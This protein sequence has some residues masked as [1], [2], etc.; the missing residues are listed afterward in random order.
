MHGT[1]T[2][3]TT[4]EKRLVLGSLCIALFMVMLDG[5]VVNVALPHIQSDLSSGVSGL[6]WIVDGYVLALASLM[7]TGGTLGDLF[8]RKRMLM[9]G[10]AIFTVGSAVCGIAPGV[11][12]LIAG[13]IL[14]GVGA[15][16]L[17]PGTLSIL[18][19]VYTDPKERA[20]AI[21]IWAGVS[22][23]ALASGPVLGGF[24]ADSLGWQ[25]IFYLNLP[26]GVAAIA[27]V[28]A[29]APESRDAAG[30]TLDLGGQ[31]SCILLLAPLTF[32]LIE[33]NTKGWTSPLILGA[34]AVSAV[35]GVTLVAIERRVASPMIP[36]HFFRNPT[37]TA[38]T[39]SG[40]LVSFALFGM[41]VF[42]SL[43]FQRVQDHS[44][45]GAGLRTLPITASMMVGMPIAG[46]LVSAFG[47]KPVMMSGMALA[48]VGMISL[49]T[50]GPETP[51]GMLWW[52]MLMIGMG[53]ALTMPSTTATV[54]GAVPPARAGI[55]SATLNTFRQVGSVLGI[56]VLGALISS[57]VASTLPARLGELGIAPASR[58]PLIEALETGGSEVSGIVPAGI[59]GGAVRDAYGVAYVEG[60]HRA[61]VAAGLSL[62]GACALIGAA[63]RSRR[64]AAGRDEVVALD[65][66]ARVDLDAAAAAAHA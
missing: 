44:A 38:A 23:V 36:L 25:S 63:V 19:N 57:R 53:M 11:G 22:G 31:V 10:I 35:A 37:F 50:L 33:G 39:V 18:S 34:F 15:A 43:Y 48:G 51:Y 41:N 6:Q 5:T 1:A 62:L 58:A 4:R 61:V 47:A 54:M 66:A 28:R 46:R 59:D 30:R 14:Q 65:P 16:A 13:R 7:L 20:Q 55:G 21:G 26:V 29:V 2:E 32:A 9:T 3:L 27:V 40:T 49:V 60:M 24:L 64:R 8:G 56:A 52:R 12:V 17:M 42:F 45:L